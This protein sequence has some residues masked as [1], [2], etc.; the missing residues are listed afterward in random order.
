MQK[1]NDKRKKRVTKK[2][3]TVA[4]DSCRR[5][6]NP[7]F[8]FMERRKGIKCGRWVCYKTHF[9]GAYL[10][11]FYF[12]KATCRLQSISFIWVQG[13]RNVF[14]FFKD[15]FHLPS[16]MDMKILQNEDLCYF[17]NSGIDQC[18]HIS[19]FNFSFSIDGLSLYVLRGDFMFSVIL[20]R[21]LLTILHTHY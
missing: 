4:I 19:I 11:F 9:R 2:Q 16:N 21:S 12:A 14:W 10:F 3:R 7:D 20:Q 5:T 8:N 18:C 15:K 6:S 17:Q 1:K 13:N